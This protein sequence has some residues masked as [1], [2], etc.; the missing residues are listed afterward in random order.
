MS[1]A[2]KRNVHPSEF[3]TNVEQ[4]TLAPLTAEKKTQS[5][6]QHW[7]HEYAA[8]QKDFQAMKEIYVRGTN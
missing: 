5:V 4:K 2:K 8:P 7:E 3:K 1:E 6:T